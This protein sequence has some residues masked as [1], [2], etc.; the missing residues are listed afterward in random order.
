MNILAAAAD[1]IVATQR[2][3]LVRN[4][5]SCINGRWLVISHIQRSRPGWPTR[6][7]RRTLSALPS[8]RKKAIYKGVWNGR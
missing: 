4:F 5:G 1:A 2:R 6:R 8:A 7:S 3:N